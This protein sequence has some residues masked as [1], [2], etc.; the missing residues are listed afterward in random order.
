MPSD[1]RREERELRPSTSRR[2][3]FERRANKRRIFLSYAYMQQVGE[4]PWERRS[5]ESRNIREEG[6]R[7]CE[8]PRKSREA[9]YVKRT[10]KSV[11]SRRGRTEFL[12]GSDHYR[13]RRRRHRERGHRR[14][15][16]TSV[17]KVSRG[18]PRKMTAK[19]RKKTSTTTCLSFRSSRPRAP[20][21]VCYFAGPWS[22]SSASSVPSADERNKV[23]S[24]RGSRVPFS[25]LRH[26]KKVFEKL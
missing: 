5:C 24:F 18:W 14:D 6:Q 22:V 8:G 26:R 23:Y 9:R 16:G 1:R 13:R 7:R 25:L 19:R 3:R 20:I 2:N 11:A 17:V 10:V 21:T 15:A 12:R 4:F